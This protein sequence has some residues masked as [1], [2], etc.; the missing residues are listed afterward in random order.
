MEGMEEII[1]DSCGGVTS[2][3]RNIQQTDYL[4]IYYLPQSACAATLLTCLMRSMTKQLTNLNF[5]I[6][7]S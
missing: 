2:L 7:D 5:L 3:N 4:S 1:V 6:N